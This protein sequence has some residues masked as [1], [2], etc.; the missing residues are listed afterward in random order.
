[1]FRLIEPARRKAVGLIGP[2]SV[3]TLEE[4]GLVV[5]KREALLETSAP[6]LKAENDRFRKALERIV[7]LE[8]GWDR[9]GG[10]S[11]EAGKVALDALYNRQPPQAK[12]LWG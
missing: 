5:I 12:G 11:S 9:W 4:A 1:M 3:K 2:G 6:E 10:Y 7:K 8:T